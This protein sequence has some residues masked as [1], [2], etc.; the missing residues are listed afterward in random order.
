MRRIAYNTLETIT[1]FV[2][3][4]AVLK[5]EF[6]DLRILTTK[7]PPVGG[8]VWIQD[9]AD[10]ASLLLLRLK[11]ATN[12]MRCLAQYPNSRHGATPHG[13]L[14]LLTLA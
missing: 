8:V 14:I 4:S 5:K 11:F 7:N 9:N 1:L 6:A 12:S 3:E 10:V 13:H 2:S